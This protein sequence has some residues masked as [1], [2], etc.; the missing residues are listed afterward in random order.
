LLLLLAAIDLGQAVMTHAHDLQVAQRVGAG[1]ERRP[2]VDVMNLKPV[3]GTAD[4]AAVT[5]CLECGGAGSPPPC[6]VAL[7]ALR[8]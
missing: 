4:L 8:V 5:G 6:A 1:V 2:A 3:G 7:R